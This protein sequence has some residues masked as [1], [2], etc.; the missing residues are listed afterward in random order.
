M[1]ANEKLAAMN[2]KIPLTIDPVLATGA[3]SK[4]ESED[5][6]ALMPRSLLF[7]TTES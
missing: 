5:D 7:L 3:C 6:D 2:I 4:R 1:H